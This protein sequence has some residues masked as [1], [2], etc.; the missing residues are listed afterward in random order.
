MNNKD[1]EKLKEYKWS[2]LEKFIPFFRYLPFIDFVLVSGSLAMNSLHK[3]SDL[4]VVVGTKYGR[5]F[6]TRF[7]T[8]MLF[9]I[10]GVRRKADDTKESSSDKICFNHFVTSESYKLS[11][12]HN[13]YWKD[14]Y[15]NLIPVYGNKEKIEDFFEINSWSDR[16]SETFSVLSKEKNLSGKLLEIIFSS[17]PGDLVEKTLKNYQKKRIDKGVEN[18][19]LGYK[20][21]LTVNDKEIRLHIDTKRVEEYVKENSN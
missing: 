9:Q 10:L 18:G 15:K 4:D 5:I 12:P 20:P 16:K 21:L 19:A 14:L 6:T 8:A 7:L 17:K 3:D 13:I 1:N 11:E 2:K